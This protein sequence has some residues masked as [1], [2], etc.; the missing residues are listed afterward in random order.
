[1]IPPMSEKKLI[2]VCADSDIQVLQRTRNGNAPLRAAGHLRVHLSRSQ[3]HSTDMETVL[4]DRLS[5]HVHLLPHKSVR[6]VSRSSIQKAPGSCKSRRLVIK[7]QKK[8]GSIRCASRNCARESQR[9]HWSR[10]FNND[11]A[12]QSGVRQEDARACTWTVCL[13]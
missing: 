8:L 12:V 10:T 11:T 3:H 7:S 2:G 13:E 1:M 6:H 9:S 5:A 4:T